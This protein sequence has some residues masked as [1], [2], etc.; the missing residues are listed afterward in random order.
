L[1]EFPDIFNKKPILFIRDGFFI[2]ADHLASPSL[3]FLE[4]LFSL[5]RFQ[6]DGGMAGCPKERRNR[7]L[8]WEYVTILPYY[9]FVLQLP[10]E[11]VE[12]R[13]ITNTTP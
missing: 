10:A 13:L 1:L 12:D 5:K 9:S 7:Y 3:G 8:L 11:R 2:V 6:G 4:R